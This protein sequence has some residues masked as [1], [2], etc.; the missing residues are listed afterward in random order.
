V[1]SGDFHRA[2]HLHGWKT[3]LPCSKD[4]AAVIRYLRSHRPAFLTRIDEAVELRDAA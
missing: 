1:A 3:L 4:E 2:E